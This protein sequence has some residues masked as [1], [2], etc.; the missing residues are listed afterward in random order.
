MLEERTLIAVYKTMEDAERTRRRLIEIGL[1]REQVSLSGEEKAGSTAD[2]EP[3]EKSGFFQAVK[4][5][6]RP[7]TDRDTYEEGVR[8]GAKMVSAHVPGQ[9]VERAVAVMEEANPLDIDTSETEWRSAGWSDYGREKKDADAGAAASS[10]RDTART[11][12]VRV[13]GR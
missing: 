3:Q 10:R 8:R 5:L 9:M 6:F 7:E 11:G 12:R 13:Y 1:P 2:Y 4:D